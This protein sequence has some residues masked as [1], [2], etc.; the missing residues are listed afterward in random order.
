MMREHDES[1]STPA[2]L[3]RRSLLAVGAVGIPGIA[4][5][6]CSQAKAPANQPAAGS[7]TPGAGSSSAAAGSSSAAATGSSSA[8]APSS[9]AAAA[10]A[11]AK[12]SDIKVGEAIS[13]KGPDGAEIIITRPT[14]TTVAAYSAICTHQGC[15]VKPAGKELDC[16]CHGS[17]F[18]LK[19]AVL[20]G[21]ARSPLGT[22]KVALSGDDVVAG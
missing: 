12:L 19:G 10:Q 9:S 18:D 8:A 3:S 14:E 2:G 15:T 13:A 6:G 16:P 4:L 1:H 5:I 11:L 22:V 17:A 7:N 20:S 21:P